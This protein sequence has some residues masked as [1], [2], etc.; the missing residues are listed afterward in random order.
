MQALS[1]T[2]A[3]SVG[4]YFLKKFFPHAPVYLSNP[5]WGLLLIIFF[6]ANRIKGNH[7]KI[8]SAAGQDV[9]FYRYFSPTTK[10]LDFEGM[11]EDLRV[12]S[13]LCYSSLFI[14]F[15]MHPRE[16]LWFIKPVLT[17]LP[18]LILLQNNGRSF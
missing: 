18:G 6:F 10:M 12:S 5:T 9:C 16:L 8:F 13:A 17:I 15:R 14:C 1:G 3:L 11:M 4:A 7:S 2:G